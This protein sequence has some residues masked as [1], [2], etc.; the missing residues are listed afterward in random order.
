MPT[1]E[2][3]RKDG[4]I[5][6]FDQ[7]FRDLAALLAAGVLTL[8]QW[9]AR[10]KEELRKLYA[11]QLLAATDGDT[12]QLQDADWQALEPT[13]QVQYSYLAGFAG[14]IVAGISTAELTARAAQ[15]T[16]ASQGVFW[17]KTLG[18]YTLPA[19]PGEGTVCH[20]GCSWEVIEHDDGSVDAYWRRTLNDSCEICI[21][22]EQDWNPYHIDA[23]AR[24]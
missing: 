5:A 23:E 21:Q 12:A 15:Y 19:Y 20:C 9:Q 7:V 17:R 1:P 14:A 10:M 24:A 22:R 8:A 6:L 2:V 16:R 18:D 13:L 11:L 4:F 3:K